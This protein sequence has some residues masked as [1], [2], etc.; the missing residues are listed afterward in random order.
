MA[1]ERSAS[2]RYCDQKR[3][4]TLKDK[5]GVSKN[6]V[7]NTDGGRDRRRMCKMQKMEDV[8]RAVERFLSQLSRVN[9]EL[10]AL[11]KRGD[12]NHDLHQQE[13]NALGCAKKLVEAIGLG[14][15]DLASY[16]DSVAEF[17]AIRAYTRVVKSGGTP[18]GET[19]YKNVIE[20]LQGEDA[21]A[22][23]ALRSDPDQFCNERSIGDIASELGIDR[24]ESA[25]LKTFLLMRQS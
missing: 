12:T 16:E 21:D 7:E 1:D 11:H 18:R 24:D 6:D 19:V 23:D 3:P 5:P 14:S 4:S 15:S 8:K 17:R 13:Q 10:V 2:A 25:D 20:S 9:H 22:Y